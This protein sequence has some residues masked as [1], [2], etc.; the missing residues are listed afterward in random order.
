MNRFS[1]AAFLLF[2]LI[3]MLTHSYS[4]AQR[5]RPPHKKSR[6]SN[7]F[8]DKQVW[9]G[10]KTG[11]NLT[12][13]NPMQRYSAFSSMNDQKSAFDK[14]YKNFSKTGWQGGLEITFFYKMVS[15]SF[16]PG[17]RRMVFEY[18]NLYRWQDPSNASN[19]MEQK[20]EAIQK[21]D[22]FEFPLFIRYE[23]LK[24][25]LRPFIQIGCYYSRLNNAVKA[26]KITVKDMASG[27]SN[28]YI[29]ED[30]SVGAKDLFIQS[31]IGWAAGAGASFP[32]GNARLSA[33]I[34]Y[35]RNTH[36][37]T[38]VEN[39]YSNERLTG[40]GDILDDVQLRNLSFFI[41]IL[42]PLRFVILKENYK[43]E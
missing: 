22:Y 8:L 25:K 40:S 16:Q 15:L 34:I 35:F 20:Y 30:I 10:L 29:A 3:L 12:K 39:R 9:I 2:A 17:Y 24:T 21:L 33:D 41:S 4:H 38:S 5:M 14:E 18:S 42:I 31:N 26:T 36:N 23:P 43:V 6:F 7:K 37:I 28:E 11:A 1:P 27:G 32:V 19:A 13:A